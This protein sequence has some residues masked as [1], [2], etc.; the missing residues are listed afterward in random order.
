[1][2]LYIKYCKIKCPNVQFYLYQKSIK[3][4][5]QKTKNKNIYEKIEKVLAKYK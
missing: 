1:M 4:A 2:K 3:N 5:P